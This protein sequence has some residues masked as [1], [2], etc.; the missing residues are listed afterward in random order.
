MQLSLYELLLC[1]REVTLKLAQ[2]HSY[3]DFNRTRVI[4]GGREPT[5]IIALSLS[6]VPVRDRLGC[7]LVQWYAVYIRA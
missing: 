1:S 3:W 4:E 6:L 5:H 2:S 7:A